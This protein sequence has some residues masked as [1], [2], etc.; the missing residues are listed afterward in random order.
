MCILEDTFST[1]V[2]HSEA[3]CKK[4][5]RDEILSTPEES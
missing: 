2:K 1:M 5:E 3:V 4:L